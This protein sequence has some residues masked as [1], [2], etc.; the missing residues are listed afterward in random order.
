LTITSLPTQ[1][2]ASLPK[3]LRN[4]RAL[5]ALSAIGRDQGVPMGVVTRITIFN[6]AV[7]PKPTISEVTR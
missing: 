2:P 6:D 3:A 7:A 5:V 4:E 1:P